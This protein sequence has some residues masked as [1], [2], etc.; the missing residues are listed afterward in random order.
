[1]INILDIYFLLLFIIV[2]NILNICFLLYDNF[3][4]KLKE[5]QFRNIQFQMYINLYNHC[6]MYI[7]IFC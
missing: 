6:L 5:F 2:I 4:K 1:M 3:N 7:F